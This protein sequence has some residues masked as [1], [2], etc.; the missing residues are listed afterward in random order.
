MST[1]TESTVTADDEQD[2]IT[3]EPERPLTTG[4]QQ[5][6]VRLGAAPIDAALSSRPIGHPQR[7][8]S[9]LRREMLTRPPLAYQSENISKLDGYED[10]AASLA[11]SVAAF[12]AMHAAVVSIIDARDKSTRD[13]TLGSEAAQVLKVATFADKLMEAA[14]RKADSAYQSLT[15]QIKATEE[16]LGRAVAVGTHTTLA[17]EI[18]AHAKS[19]KSPA[20]FVGNLIAQGDAQSVSAILGA[21]AFLSGLTEDMRAALIKQWNAKR[22]PALTKRLALLQAVSGKLEHAGASLFGTVE[23]AMGV[24]YETVKRLRDAQAAAS[25]G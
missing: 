11:G 22:N 18:R 5:A 14:S 2:S 21:P 15:A 6:A 24:K 3:E 10:H 4:E 13:P 19:E 8:E 12:D 9:K 25:F 17:T 7:Y 1:A 16:E 23:R 20:Q